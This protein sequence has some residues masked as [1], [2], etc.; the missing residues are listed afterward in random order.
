MNT[1]RPPFDGDCDRDRD[2]ERDFDADL[3]SELAATDNVLHRSLAQLLAPPAD[4]ESRTQDHVANSLMSRSLLGTGADLLTVGWQTL[5]LMWSE[6][7]P[8]PDADETE[9][10]R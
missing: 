1:E 9:V 4:L 2:F 10:T 3:E 8:E 6:P 7:E 5:R